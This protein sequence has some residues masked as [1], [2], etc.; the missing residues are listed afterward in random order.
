MELSL[1]SPKNQAILSALRDNQLRRAAGLLVDVYGGKVYRACCTVA[2]AETAEE[3]CYGGL[4]AAFGQLPGFRAE[5]SPGHWLLAV[6][7][8]RCAGEIF[9]GVPLS[10][11]PCRALSGE[12]PAPDLAAVRHGLEQLEREERALVGLAYGFGLPTQPFSSGLLAQRT[13]AAFA[14]LLEDAASG[15]PVSEAETVT[16]LRELHWHMNEPLRRR[17]QMLC[18]ALAGT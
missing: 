14:Q 12:G 1:D 7:R 2:D 10:V 9:H 15:G 17:L 11:G 13:E 8:A 5:E 6:A 16:A 3:L 4:S 18:T